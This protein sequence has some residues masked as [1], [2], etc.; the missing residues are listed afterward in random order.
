MQDSF[1]FQYFQT[2]EELKLTP[3]CRSICVTLVVGIGCIHYIEE[4]DCLAKFATR[5]I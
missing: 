1:V 2:M 5:A 3:L 4:K